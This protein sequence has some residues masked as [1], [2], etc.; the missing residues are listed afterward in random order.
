[1]PKLEVVLMHAFLVWPITPV[2]GSSEFPDGR[3]IP[4]AAMHYLRLHCGIHVAS[5][6]ISFAKRGKAF[7]LEVVTGIAADLHTISQG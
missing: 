7:Y 4:F 5:P 6:M 2:K 1:M 3:R